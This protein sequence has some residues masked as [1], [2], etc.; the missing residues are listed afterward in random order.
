MVSR[1]RLS[2][3]RSGLVRRKSPPKTMR[4]AGKQIQ[5]LGFAITQSSK[6]P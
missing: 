6:E 3:C 1:N 4:Q 5:A 2:P